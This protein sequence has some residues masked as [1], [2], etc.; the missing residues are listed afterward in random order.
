MLS[1][2]KPLSQS[3][4]PS[5][6]R[7]DL[8][9]GL[10][11]LVLFAVI[12][13]FTPSNYF[14]G[15]LILFFLW[16]TVVT[17]WNLVFGVGG[18]FSLA[19]MALF[20]FGGFVTGIMGLYLG[21]SLWAALP[22]AGIGSVLFSLLIGLACLRLR[23]PYVAL[24]TLAIAQVMYLLIITDTDCFY[25]EG[26]TC[27]N[28][29]GGTR[30]LAKYGDFGFRDILGAKWAVG[31]YYMG[32]VM[33]ALSTVMSISIIRGPLGLAF[34]A[35]RDNPAYAVSR[36]LD[37]F[38]YQ[39]IVF[40]MSAFFTGVAGGVYAGHF[41]VI[42]ANVLYLSLL[43]FLLAMM[44]VGGIGRVWGPILGAA[45]LM[46][47]DEGL[48]D[49]VEWR[50]IGLGLIIALFAMLWPQ[51]IVGA[52]EAGWARLRQRLHPEKIAEP[53]PARAPRP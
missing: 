2:F 27:R 6:V 20:A 24:L 35:L 18:I 44:I 53:G 11:V 45:A 10:P 51:G 37:R 4:R 29:T 13:V 22:I 31:H 47:A 28:F 17:Q 40:A 39:L 3:V 14:L 36:G 48:K 12:P 43:L 26:V 5:T 19:Q 9:V 32:L 23:G 34:R 30:G 41:K 49:Y 8:S 21:W 15:Q 16:G 52:V 7:F 33:L 46:I 1:L 42:G 50:N 25:M 38:K